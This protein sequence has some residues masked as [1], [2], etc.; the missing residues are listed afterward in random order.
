MAK[1]SLFSLSIILCKVVAWVSFCIWYK[2]TLRLDYSTNY[3]SNHCQLNW[4]WPLIRQSISNVGGHRENGGPQA[5]NRCYSFVRQCKRVSDGM[6][7][8][9]VWDTG[10]LTGFASCVCVLVNERVSEL[11]VSE[12][13]RIKRNG[14]ICVYECKMRP[15]GRNIWLVKEEETIDTDNDDGKKKLTGDTIAIYNRNKKA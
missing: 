10:V 6:K 12:T 14:N 3:D 11:Y 15:V 8:V 9:N 2:H 13:W 1:R 7:W 4:T 5:K